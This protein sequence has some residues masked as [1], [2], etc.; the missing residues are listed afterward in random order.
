MR[1]EGLEAFV[2]PLLAVAVGPLLHKVGEGLVADCHAVVGELHGV[3][4][5]KDVG[6]D[7]ATAIDGAAAVGLVLQRVVEVDRVLV[8]HLVVA[9]TLLEVATVGVGALGIGALYAA[10]RRGIVAGCGETQLA[11]VAE[12]I[13]ALHQAF[14]KGA[15][16]DD[17]GTVPVLQSSRDDLRRRGALL[18]DEHHHVAVDELARGGAHLVVATLLAAFL[19][20][21]QFLGVEKLVGQ[22]HSYLHIAAAIATEVEDEGLHALPLQ[23][24]KC[25]TELGGTGEREAYE[26]DIA[27]AVAVE[28][29]GGNAI[30]GHL[31]TGDGVGEL[32][33]LTQHVDLHLGAFGTAE[34]LIDEGVVDAVAH[35]REAVDAYHLVAYHQASLLGG[36]L[37]YD[38]GE[39][40]GV[41]ENL[42]RDAHA[43]E[44]AVETFI[45]TLHIFGRDIDAVGVEALEHGHHGSLAELVHVGSVDILAVD[46]THHLFDTVDARHR[47]R[48]GTLTLC[49]RREAEQHQ[50]TH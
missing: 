6:H 9:V 46:H 16:A 17:G 20:D 24:G 43:V 12:L 1:Q 13:L 10:A 49:C 33:T 34:M 4:R 28:E 25:P 27:N 42:E 31:A 2:G 7:A 30:D 40:N 23:V 15:T 11:A 45:G 48:V 37:L 5:H 44:A 18:V 26:V 19:V 47:H 39:D 3:H 50:C 36:A 8:D 21:Y 38:V 35:G 29:M 22:L 32:D 14:A 41:V